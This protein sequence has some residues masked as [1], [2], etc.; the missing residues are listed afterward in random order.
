MTEFERI[1]AADPHLRGRLRGLLEQVET[2]EDVFHQVATGQI[3]DGPRFRED[4]ATSGQEYPPGLR[5]A[6]AQMV[7]ALDHLNAW[8]QIVGPINSAAPMPIY[9]HYSIARAC[10]EAALWVQWLLDP[11]VSSI[12]RVGRGY[13][14]N[15]HSLQ[16]YIKY[17]NSR[18]GT[19]Q[20]SDM[21]RYLDLT[22][23]AAVA[24]GVAK[25]IPTGFKMKYSRS[26][27][28]KLF[29]LYIRDRRQGDPVWL[30]RYL[31]AHAHGTEW[32]L[33]TVAEDTTVNG[34]S[35]TRIA[36]D[37]ESL[38]TVAQYLVP[39]VRLSLDRYVSYVRAL[40]FP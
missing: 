32:S 17:Q 14:M 2:L 34:Q 23:A 33:L 19:A 28:G 3:G 40:P 15:A 8:R 26:E 1:T 30:Y 36:T 24:V 27:I 12:E 21:A 4:Q 9:A 18:A 7:S 22:V 10:F 20:F 5:A 13:A 38:V 37:L 11:Q 31:S 6:Q 16:E 35:M 25:K 39:T 29:S